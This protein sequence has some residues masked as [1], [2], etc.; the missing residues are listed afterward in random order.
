MSTDMSKVKIADLLEEKTP[1]SITLY[2]SGSAIYKRLCKIRT[3]CKTPGLTW[4]PEWFLYWKKADDFL[5]VNLNLEMLIVSDYVPEF[6]N[7]IKTWRE[8]VPY[9]DIS[10]IAD[11]VDGQFLNEDGEEKEKLNDRWS[12]NTYY[13]IGDVGGYESFS[14]FANTRFSDDLHT[15]VGGDIDE[16]Y[17]DNWVE[18]E[19]GIVPLK[20]LKFFS[21]R[22]SGRLHGGEVLFD[23]FDLPR[24]LDETFLSNTKFK[25][26]DHE[27]LIS[28]REFISEIFPK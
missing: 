11:F 17:E 2:S 8:T 15:W 25:I 14:V 5:K 23:D 28:F 16:E 10:A 13:N 12:G 22:V 4:I 21:K 6:L 9:H 1:P 26:G 19:S 20:D 24:L 27:K 7:F 3:P 18:D